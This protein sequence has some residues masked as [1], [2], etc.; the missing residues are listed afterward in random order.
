MSFSVFLA[1]I[2]DMLRIFGYDG[3]LYGAG[4]VPVP[5]TEDGTAAVMDGNAGPPP[6]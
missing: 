3:G 4:T 1:V 2:L 6:R 5:T